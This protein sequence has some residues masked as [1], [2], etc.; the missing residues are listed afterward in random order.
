MIEFLNK[1]GPLII[2]KKPVYTLDE[3][4]LSLSKEQLIYIITNV[5]PI[6]EKFNINDKKE[7]LVN[8]LKK[9]IV[10]RMKY[11]FK[12]KA[13]LA[14]L[15][16]LS[17]CTHS[18]KDVQNVIDK[19]VEGARN[20]NIPVEQIEDVIID[21]VDFF[22]TTGMVFAFLPKGASELE[23]C[24]PI[25]LAKHYINVIK[26]TEG[27]DEHGKYFPFVNYA[28][29]LASLYGACSVEQF[30]EI[31]NRDNKSAKITD[32]KIAIQFLKE[33]TEIDMNF[34]YEN[35]YISTFWVYAEHEKDYI[36]EA[37]KNFLPYIPS[38]KE[39]E[40]KLTQISY[41]DDNENCE[42][43]FKYLEKKKIDH[44]IIRFIIFNLQIRIQLEGNAT[45]AIEYLIN[46]SDISFSDI[47]E[48]NQLTPYV[49][50]LNNS[51]HLWT[52][53]GNVPNQMINVSKKTAKSSKKDFLTEEAKEN[54]EKQKMEM[55]KI[56][57]PPDL[58]IPTEKECIKASKEFD[59]YWKRD[60]YEDPPDWF[61]EGDN[62]L[63]RISAFRGK[64]RTEIDKIPQSSQN[65]LYEQWIASVWHKNANRGG[66]F[67]NQ[68]WDFHAFSIGQKLGNDLFACKDADG[69][70][71]VIFSHSLQINYDENLLTCV[72][73]L[74]DMGGFYMTYG[75]VMGWK[76][77]IPSD[78]DY[79][80]YC[81]AN[82]L[83]DNQGMSSVFQFNP[84]PLWG[85][86]GISEMPPLM[87]KG[88]MVMSCVLETAFK[89]NKVPEFNKKWIMEK[90]KNG[91]LTRWSNN[92]DY[93]ASTI[94][95]YD[96]KLNKVVILGH[97]REDFENTI[98]RFKDS[99]YLKNKP[100]I[101]T[102]VMDTQVFSLFKRKN[103]LSQME[104][105]F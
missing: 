70:V 69:S 13:P 77:I 15:L 44:N 78:I 26:A 90:S 34:I 81:T 72:T 27:E 66:R 35:G 59:L 18:K 86:F 5:I 12:Y 16:F 75:P 82:Q 56:D 32:K 84:W 6:T 104:S 92:N 9:K 52:R 31:Y 60:E 96:E 63:R 39:L 40:K 38:K 64:F 89:D 61:S 93:L 55:V 33:A 76:G 7:N 79:L 99:L 1:K 62:Y 101:C 42:L 83:Y 94:I 100:E 50:E 14:R 49:V 91:K 41:E 37:R 28:R 105:N 17:F 54:I 88:K 67:G 74:I 2:K 57:L 47:D 85:A 80:A 68:K 8:K 98:N 51:M 48:I 20:F 73:L 58:K 24:A 25:E 3:S 97:N 65:K 29:L 53:H 22:V 21:Y 103:L 36:I 87:H 43:I 102:M 19:M 95:Y 30:M 23:L 45:N 10:Q 11:V 4:L 46:E 71:Y